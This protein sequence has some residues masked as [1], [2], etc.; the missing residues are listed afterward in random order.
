MGID[1]LLVLQEVHDNNTI[2]DFLRNKKDEYMKE[3]GITDKYF[4]LAFICAYDLFVDISKFTIKTFQEIHHLRKLKTYKMQFRKELSKNTELLV[5]YILS[6]NWLA[7]L[8]NKKP[9]ITLLYN[10]NKIEITGESNSWEKYIVINYENY[11]KET[12]YKIDQEIFDSVK[13]TFINR[14]KEIEI[15]SNGNPFGLT[16]IQAIKEYC[17]SK[18]PAQYVDKQKNEVR[19]IFDAIAFKLGLNTKL[20]YV[21]KTG[22]YENKECVGVTCT[23]SK[24]QY[25]FLEELEVKIKLKYNLNFDVL[26]MY[27][28]KTIV[29]VFALFNEFSGKITYLTD[30]TKLYVDELTSSIKEKI[31]KTIKKCLNTKLVQKACSD[32]NLNEVKQNCID[33]IDKIKSPTLD[34]ENPIKTTEIVQKYKVNIVHELYEACTPIFSLIKEDQ[35]DNEDFECPIERFYRQSVQIL[36]ETDVLGFDDKISRI[37]SLQKNVNDELENI[38]YDDTN[39]HKIFASN[40]TINNLLQLVEMIRTTAQAQ[41][42]KVG[43][44]KKDEVS[45]LSKLAADED[46]KLFIKQ[47]N[48]VITN[49]LNNIIKLKGILIEAQQDAVKLIENIRKYNDDGDEPIEKIR[50]TQ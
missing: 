35:K 6:V 49:I 32:N 15:S 7:R 11:D 46:F 40:V 27:K 50:K 2:E 42:K 5:K 12:D 24:L 36:N 21:A 3:K 33:A 9:L 48:I 17:I 19:F 13:E 16:Y 25:K 44:T 29:N 26:Q 31:E 43:E 23:L 4:D 39:T 34:S 41:N 18:L 10:F 8:H 22:Y 47:N 28:T 30:F 1:M 45:K 14:C 37:I 20:D 38:K